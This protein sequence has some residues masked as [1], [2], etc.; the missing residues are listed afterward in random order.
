M[1]I[2]WRKLLKQFVQFAALL[3]GLTLFEF[4][5]HRTFH[6]GVQALSADQFYQD[7][8]IAIPFSLCLV[9]SRELA[10]GGHFRTK[11]ILIRCAI[12]A[13]AAPFVFLAA[14]IIFKFGWFPPAEAPFAPFYLLSVVFFGAALYLNRNRK[15]S[16]PQQAYEAESPATMLGK[17]EVFSKLLF[18]I[19][20]SARRQ[21]T[22]LI[23]TDKEPL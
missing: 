7:I 22:S 13:F 17:E 20:L 15:V 19:G 16:T 5:L 1:A 18:L 4:A 9:G 2:I 3:V 23:A 14:A 10:R 8:S 11:K 12:G 21:A 6:F